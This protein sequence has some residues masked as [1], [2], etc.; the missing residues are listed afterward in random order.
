M[1]EDLTQAVVE[2]MRALAAGLEGRGGELLR[3]MLRHHI[4]WSARC[5]AAGKL[6]RPRLCLLCC[7]AVGGDARAAVPAAAAVELIHNFSLV[8]DDIQDRDEMRRGR[9]TVW[10]RWG[11]AQAISAGDCLYALA[12]AALGKQARRVDAARRLRAVAMLADACVRLCEGQ[13]HDLALQGQAQISQVEYLEMIGRK[14]AALISCAAQMGAM[15]GGADDKAAEAFRRFGFDLGLAFQVRDDLLGLW[16]DVKQTGKPV[17]ADLGRRRCSYPVV[18]ALERAQPRQREAI[19]RAQSA[20][21][22]MQ[23]RAAVAA[24]ERLGAREQ[25]ECLAQE[26]HQRAWQALAGL[27]L[28]PGPLRALRELSDFLITRGR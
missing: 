26:M 27:K 7:Q 19:V 8:H 11:E 15:L 9:P 5:P 20:P 18:W 10:A 12:Y 6:V 17:G 13:S 21:S 28:K 1:K 24:L 2:H 14:T 25:G 23:V 16:G 3:A 22:A 4:G